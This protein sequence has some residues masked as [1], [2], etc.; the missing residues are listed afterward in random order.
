MKRA[1]IAAMIA[2]CAASAPAKATT[3]LSGLVPLGSAHE[4]MTDTMSGP[5]QDFFTFQ[6]AVPHELVSSSIAIVELPGLNI[7]ISPSQFRLEDIT[8]PGLP[9]VLEVA[10]G[11]GSSPVDSFALAPILLSAGH[12]Y[13]FVVAGSIPPSSVGIY[14]IT[15]FGSVPA[16]PE[17][18]SWAMM[19]LGFASIGFMAYRRKPKPAL[20]VA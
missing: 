16:V 15:T 18:S 5:V 12:N 17:A 10:D 3:Y 13:E 14:S 7:Q 9:V 19:L 1:L 6:T 4:A 2:G 11:S 20:M 8:N